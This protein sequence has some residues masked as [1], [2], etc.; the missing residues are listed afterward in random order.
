MRSVVDRI[1]TA[2]GITVWMR[3]CSDRFY[4]RPQGRVGLRW[5]INGID[6]LTLDGEA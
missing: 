1:E 4:E 6:T 5:H 2:A 3:H